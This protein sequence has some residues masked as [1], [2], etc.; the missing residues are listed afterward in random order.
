MNIRQKYSNYLL[1]H[2]PW[3]LL[4]LTIFIVSSISQQHLPEFTEK[5]SDKI[6]HFSAFGMLGLLMVNSFKHSRNNILQNYAGSLAVIISSIYGIF[7]ELHQK[8]VPG[9]M[10]SFT[11][12][13]ADTTGALIL[14]LIFMVFW[15]YRNKQSAREQPEQKNGPG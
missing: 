4:I 14:V 9:R 11:D 3:Q 10:C 12:W 1:Y 6:L 8:L 7:D 2:F 15:Y 13:L 5:I